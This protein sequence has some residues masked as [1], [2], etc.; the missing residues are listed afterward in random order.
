MPPVAC[1]PCQGTCLQWLAA[2]ASPCVPASPPEPSICRCP[3]AAAAAVRAQSQARTPQRT[4]EDVIVSEHAYIRVHLHPKRFP[5]T[6]SVDWAVSA[7]VEPPACALGDGGGWQSD[8]LV[9]WLLC[10]ISCLAASVD[11]PPA[12]ST[13]LMQA[14]IVA[15]TDEFVVVCKP[16]GVPAAATVDNLLECAPTCA[17]QVIPPTGAVA[18]DPLQS[19]K[20]GCV[21]K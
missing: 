1:S 9:G 13:P 6:Y 5:A 14:R 10:L 17:A 7:A 3:A 20:P 18:A 4:T 15:N 8:A 16:P 11:P 2:G 19:C 21:R 12:L